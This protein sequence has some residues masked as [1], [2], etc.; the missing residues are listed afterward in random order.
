MKYYLIAGEA[1]GDLHASKLMAAL[2]NEDPAAQFRYIGGDRMTAVG[3]ERMFHFKDIAYMGFVPVLAHLDVILKA[4]RDCKRDIAAWKPDVVILVDY[5]DFNLNIAKYVKTAAAF[6]ER[7]PRVYYYISPKI[8]A[9]K[10]GRIKLFRRYVDEMFCIL[11]FEKDFFEGRHRYKV[12]Y[13]GNPTASEV[14]EFKA[15]EHENKAAFCRKHA[16]DNRPIVAL[17]AGSRR[18]EIKDN[19]P[20]MAHVAERY[21]GFQF[22]VAQVES[23]ENEYYERIL[24]GTEIKRVSSATYA[25]LSHADAALVTSGTATL[26]TCCFDVPQVVLYKTLLPRVSRFVWDRFFR[27]KYISLVN[28]IAD[29][30]VVAEMMAEK[31]E[32]SAVCREFER[33]LP[34]S[35]DRSIMLEEYKK[36]R[37]KL[38]D[39]PAHATAA[40]AMRECLLSAENQ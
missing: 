35:P 8:W 23:V 25:L 11:P 24:R 27:V 15:A 3:G 37:E 7:R 22:V 6:T 1:S 4:R 29:K 17:L 28:L 16:L 20:M 26:E 13:T 40:H 5:A 34:G 12:H 30:E 33:I 10:E 32:V 19:L 31:F 9:W 2:R 39:T 21:A 14:R 38:G 18:Q 36:V